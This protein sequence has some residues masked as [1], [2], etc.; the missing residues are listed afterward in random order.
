MGIWH[1]PN[2]DWANLAVLE[3]GCQCSSTKLPTVC[4]IYTVVN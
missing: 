4:P 3:A 2:C 1:V